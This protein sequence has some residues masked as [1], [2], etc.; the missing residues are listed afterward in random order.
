[1]MLQKRKQFGAFASWYLP[2][3]KYFLSLGQ[4]MTGSSSPHKNAVCGEEPARPTFAVLQWGTASA[5][6]ANA[7]CT[8]FKNSSGLWTT[9]A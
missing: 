9:C 5:M 6:V 2:W 8:K 3:G 7:L 1:M 4:K